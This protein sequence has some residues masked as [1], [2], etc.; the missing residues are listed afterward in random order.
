MS[1]RSPFALL[2]GL[3]AT[4]IPFAVLAGP[5]SDAVHAKKTAAARKPARTVHPDGSVSIALE[6][7]AHGL[8]AHIGG[9]GRVRIS[10]ME[11]EH[12]L[13]D[14]RAHERLRDTDATAWE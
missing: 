5:S 13:L 7:S 11:T 6:Q 12:T 8:F 9:D 2:A 3:L 14:K 10:C 4:A 1:T